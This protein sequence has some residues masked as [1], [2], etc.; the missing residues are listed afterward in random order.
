M[1]VA[2]HNS[3]GNDDEGAIC[4]ALTELGHQVTCIAE[5]GGRKDA[6]RL[7]ADHDFLLFHKW[8][9]WDVLSRLSIQKVFF[10]FDMVD[11]HDPTLAGR[12]S[13]R[14]EW[15]VNAYTVADLG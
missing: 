8:S 9:D 11:S 12:Y 15:T 4:Y 5:D 3:G 6:V 7:Q 14:R 13:D 1:Y 10:Y 2:K